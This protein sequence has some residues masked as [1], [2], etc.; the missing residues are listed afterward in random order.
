[1]CTDSATSQPLGHDG[2]DI[3]AALLGSPEFLW[4]NSE[5]QSNTMPPIGPEITVEGVAGAVERLVAFLGRDLARRS[6]EAWER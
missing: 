4:V 3:A 5:V 6:S 2:A 1:M